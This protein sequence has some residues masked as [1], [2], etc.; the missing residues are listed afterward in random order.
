MVAM[1]PEPSLT[2]AFDS[3]ERWWEGRNFRTKN[4]ARAPPKIQRK[5]SKEIN[6][7]LMVIPS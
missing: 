6:N 3:G 5:A 2:A 1:S 7:G 4:P